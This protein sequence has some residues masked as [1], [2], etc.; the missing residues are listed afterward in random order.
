VG[1]GIEQLA[2]GQT[3]R[4]LGGTDLGV[5]GHERLSGELRRRPG[6]LVRS[7]GTSSGEFPGGTQQ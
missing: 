2:D 5:N 6:G 1:V 7:M 4:G 3:V